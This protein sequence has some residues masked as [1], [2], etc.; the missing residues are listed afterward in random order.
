[1]N[2]SIVRLTESAFHEILQFV[3]TTSRLA[4]R[5]P[6]VDSLRALASTVLNLDEMVVR[7]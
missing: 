3:A 2:A 5:K 6:L 1:M 4:E 7:N